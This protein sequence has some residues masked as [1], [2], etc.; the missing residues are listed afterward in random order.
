MS[1]A[2]PLL[3]GGT[4]VVTALKIRAVFLCCYLCPA[5]AVAGVARRQ[6]V[7]GLAG[8]SHGEGNP[9]RG[10]M[11]SCSLLVRDAGHCETAWPQRRRTR[12]GFAST[13]QPPFTSTCVSPGRQR[14]P[15]PLPG[16]CQCHTDRRGPP[17]PPSSIICHPTRTIKVWADRRFPQQGAG[18][19]G[20][21][22]AATTAARRAS[23]PPLSRSVCRGSRT[24]MAS[25]HRPFPRNLQ[26]RLGKT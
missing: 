3:P 16:E 24:A 7:G 2:R 13:P 21:I 26:R 1:R 15:P 20:R 17:R 12:R 4:P 6:E 10:S 22:S 14:Q 5:A 25:V 11:F 18:E 9:H 8:E 23:R 19:G